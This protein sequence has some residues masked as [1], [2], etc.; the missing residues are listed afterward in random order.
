MVVRFGGEEFC[1]L[2]PNVDSADILER[3]EEL[4]HRVASLNPSGVDITISVGLASTQDHPDTSLTRFIGMA[5][6]ALYHAKANGRN[7]VCLYAEDGPI[8][9]PLHGMPMDYQSDLV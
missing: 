7:K 2:I 6:K 5:D 9:S 3:A 8:T 4:R 1:V